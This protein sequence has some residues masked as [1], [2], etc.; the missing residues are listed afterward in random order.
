MKA[1]EEDRRVEHK[2]VLAAASTETRQIAPAREAP[3]LTQ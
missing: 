3:W 2:G 1:R